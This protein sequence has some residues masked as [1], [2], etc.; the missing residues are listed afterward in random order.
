MPVPVQDK[1]MAL[2]WARSA[3]DSYVGVEIFYVE[4]ADTPQ[5]ADRSTPGGKFLGIVADL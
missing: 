4:M 3:R 5:E 1:G 2:R